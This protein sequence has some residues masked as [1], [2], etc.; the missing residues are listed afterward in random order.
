MNLRE[1]AE[2][3]LGLT[4]ESSNDWGLPV[5]LRS[6]DGEI[7]AYTVVCTASDISFASADSSVNSVTTDFRDYK[8]DV[9]D[10]LQFSG[11]TGNTSTYTVSSIAENKIVVAESVTTEAAGSEIKIVNQN[12]PLNGQ[13]MYD[14]LEV[15]TDTGVEDLVHKPVVTLRRTSL[16]RIPLQSEKNQW[17]VSIPLTP[18]Q[19]ATLQPYI[20]DRPMESGE[21][22]GFIRLYLSK[23]VQS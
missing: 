3:D 9:D 17:L 16:V 5:T 20:M 19:T 2:R 21:S 6:P 13:V 12:R 22:I 11:S 23:P 10:V 1:L 18:S 15:N 8:I 4:L 7:Q 14:T